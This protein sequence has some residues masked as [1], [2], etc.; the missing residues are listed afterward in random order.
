MNESAFNSKSF[1]VGGVSAI[2]IYSMAD[3][4]SAYIFPQVPA[5]SIALALC[6]LAAFAGLDFSLKAD[7]TK[8]V[9]TVLTRSGQLFAV[10]AF[11]ALSLFVTSVGSNT[12]EG[13]GHARVVAV[14]TEPVAS[15]H[16]FANRAFAQE[17][18][19]EPTPRP[20]GGTWF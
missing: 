20:A 7:E 16:W 17:P 12:L 14:I 2:L 3:R 8:T 18:E 10:W 19:P 9:G 5:P 15:V 11:A 13:A 4:L 6:A 1:A